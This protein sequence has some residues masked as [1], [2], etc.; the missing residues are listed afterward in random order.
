MRMEHDVLEICESAS[1][2]IDVN[3]ELVAVSKYSQNDNAD[4]SA[5]EHKLTPIPRGCIESAS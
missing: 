5:I 1:L 4:S 3:S 2:G